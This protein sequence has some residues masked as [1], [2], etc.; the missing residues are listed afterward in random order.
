MAR[1]MSEHKHRELA[2]LEKV[3][4]LCELLRAISEACPVNAPRD[5]SGRLC[6]VRDTEPL[7]KLAVEFKIENGGQDSLGQAAMIAR[8]MLA[9]FGW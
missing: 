3:E 7:H 6:G 5:R 8:N 1:H 2:L 9:A 4:K